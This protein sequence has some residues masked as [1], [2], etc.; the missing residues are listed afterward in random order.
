M[1]PHA[2]PNAAK[3][4]TAPLSCILSPSVTS[5]HTPRG[6]FYVFMWLK[7]LIFSVTHPGPCFLKFC[8]DETFVFPL[9]GSHLVFQKDPR[10]RPKMEGL[11]A[12]RPGAS[13][14]HTRGLRGQDTIGH[15]PRGQ[16]ES[17]KARVPKIFSRLEGTFECLFLQ[18]PVPGP[19][20]QDLEASRLSLLLETQIHL[21]F[22]QSLTDRPPWHSLSP[23]QSRLCLETGLPSPATD[24]SRASSQNQ[25]RGYDQLGLC[26]PMYPSKAGS[27]PSSV[28]VQS[29]SDLGPFS[30]S[31]Y[32]VPVTFSFPSQLKGFPMSSYF[33]AWFSISV[34]SHP[35]TPPQCD[36]TWR[37][38]NLGVA[39]TWGGVAGDLGVSPGCGDY[40]EFQVSPRG[41]GPSP[42]A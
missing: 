36:I 27:S 40:P 12:Y 17:T 28:S 30:C 21:G 16:T 22:Q 29:L 10:Q 32:G 14:S 35:P 33:L 2:R 18:C 26:P 23:K 19:L 13:R 39:R 31:Q 5:F 25:S 37:T 20:K 41:T 38:G 24:L 9:G 34:I 3:Q 15:Q 6:M 1:G 8:P 7:L 42:G 4:A 11:A